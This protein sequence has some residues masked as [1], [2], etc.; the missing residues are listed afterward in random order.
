MTRKNGLIINHIP[1][2]TEQMGTV[3]H[4][5]QGMPI[6]CSRSPDCQFCQAA[7]RNDIETWLA[8]I[9]FPWHAI[10]KWQRLNI[11]IWAIGKTIKRMCARCRVE[12]TPCYK[13]IRK[14]CEEW[15]ST[16]EFWGKEQGCPFNFEGYCKKFDCNHKPRLLNPSNRWYA[17]ARVVRGG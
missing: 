4:F 8:T 1:D 12:N 15:M 11:P 13:C 14:G 10:S 6:T 3:V 17:K 2:P 9:P 16:P 7:K 5:I